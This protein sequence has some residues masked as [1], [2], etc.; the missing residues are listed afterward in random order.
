MCCIQ[1]VLTFSNFHLHG[2]TIAG[3]KELLRGKD[4]HNETRL[5]FNIQNCKYNSAKI[6]HV[7]KN[8]QYQTDD[9][10]RKVTAETQDNLN[11]FLKIKFKNQ[12]GE[13]I[14]ARRTIFHVYLSCVH[15]FPLQQDQ[16]TASSLSLNMTC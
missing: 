13:K 8:T 12:K 2:E 15:W 11:H 3:T 5:P 16:K 7:R 14:K 1:K 10:H 9:F 4:K 6:S